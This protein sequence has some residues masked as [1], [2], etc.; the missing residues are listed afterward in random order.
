M[1]KKLLFLVLTIPNGAI[2]DTWNE[3]CLCAKYAIANYNYFAFI[4]SQSNS[5]D[6]PQPRLYERYITS[7][8]RL[9]E[10]TSTC[11]SNPSL[12][13]CGTTRYCQMQ[14]IPG[15]DKRYVDYLKVPNSQ[16]HD[17]DRVM[18]AKECGYYWVK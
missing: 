15:K 13:I 5:N 2:A 17:P 4:D 16:H 14:L 18:I 9:D 1:F 3:G 8:R 7:K 6:G 10:T 11:R 12:P